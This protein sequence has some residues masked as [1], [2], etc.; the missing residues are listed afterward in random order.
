VSVVENGRDA[1]KIISDDPEKYNIILLDLMMA[2]IGGYEVLI[3]LKD[4]IE[5]LKT[6]EFYRLRIGIAPKGT[7]K[8]GL[9]PPHGEVVQ[10]YVLANFSEEEKEILK[11][12]KVLDRVKIFLENI[13][14]TLNTIQ[15]VFILTY[16]LP[17]SMLCNTCSHSH[18]LLSFQFYHIHLFSLAFF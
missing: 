16:N 14:N 8:E 10:R 12:Y 1:I 18:Y 9:I 11:D 5:K 7:G 15:I 2:D 6:K 4:I 3:H 17:I 13:I